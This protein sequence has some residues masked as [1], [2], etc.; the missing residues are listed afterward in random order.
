MYNHGFIYSNRTC[1]RKR[2]IRLIRF[3]DCYNNK[4][5]LRERVG[6][7]STLFLRLRSTLIRFKYL[8]EN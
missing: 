3:P 2:G 8:I 7:I 5:E 1:L 4:D 6:L